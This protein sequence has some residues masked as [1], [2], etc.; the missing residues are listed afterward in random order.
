MIAVYLTLILAV[1]FYITLKAI[2]DYKK[3]TKN[4]KEN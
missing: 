2:L 4:N 3:Q 1:T